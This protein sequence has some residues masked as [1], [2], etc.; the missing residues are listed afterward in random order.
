MNKLLEREHPAVFDAAYDIGSRRRRAKF[1]ADKY[2]AAILEKMAR[3]CANSGRTEL[4]G[5]LKILNAVIASP[6]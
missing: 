1:D 2:R 4:A 3:E 5:E 6:D